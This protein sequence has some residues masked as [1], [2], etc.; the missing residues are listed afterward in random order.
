MSLQYVTYCSNMSHIA[1]I[2]DMALLNEGKIC[3][4]KMKKC[5]KQTAPH[6][7]SD[8]NTR[9]GKD[10]TVWS[11]FSSPQGRMRSRNII[12]TRLHGVCASDIYTPND[13]F[14]IFFSENIVEEI[15]LCTNL[16]SRRVA[17]KWNAVQKD[18]I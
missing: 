7:P 11:S 6:T 10:G 13:A 3:P 18:K 15:M 14:Q 12:N 16:Q 4:Y 1:A 5:F 17:T 9:T 2:C 8:L